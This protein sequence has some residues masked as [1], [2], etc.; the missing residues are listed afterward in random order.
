VLLFASYMNF[1]INRRG[2]YISIDHVVQSAGYLDSR[3]VAGCACNAGKLRFLK[4]TQLSRG[5]DI[6]W[7]ISLSLARRWNSVQLNEANP[8]TVQNTTETAHDSDGS[9]MLWLCLDIWDKVLIC[10]IGY[11]DTF[12]VLNVV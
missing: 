5:N 2:K 8:D 12:K 10:H 1:A 7:Q 9:I 4:R 11:M 3:T 6:P